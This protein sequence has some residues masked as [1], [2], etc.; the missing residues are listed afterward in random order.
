MNCVYT[1]L[2]ISY[3]CYIGVVLNIWICDL[4]V[5]PWLLGILLLSYYRY[6]LFLF[7]F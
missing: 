6:T 5:L 4:L 1:I 3:F 7:I 2:I